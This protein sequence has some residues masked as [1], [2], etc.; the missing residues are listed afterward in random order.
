MTVFANGNVVTAHEV[1]RGTVS[2][3]SGV[4]GQVERY[5]TAEDA[6][7]VDLD[8]DYLLPGI[9]ELHTDVLERH[10]IPRPGAEWPRVAAVV[11]YDSQLI[12]AG[13]TTVLDSLAIGYLF[14]TAQRPR[15]PRP[16][17]E[18]IRAA[19]AADLLR[20]DHY[21]HMRCEVSTELV[22]DDFTPF[23]DDPL[24]RLV[25]LMDHSP[26]QRQ[27]VSVET[28]RQFNQARYGLSDT[29]VDELV[30]TRIEAR[31]RYAE[32]HREAIT[33]LC[34]KHGLPMASHDDALVTHVE[35]AVRAGASIAEFPTTLEAARTARDYGLAV[36]AGAPN[37]VRGGSHSGNISV[38]QLAA[39][40]LLDILSSDYVPVSALHGAFI[41]HLHHGMSL[42]DAVATI[43]LTPARRVGL[44]DRGEIA[45]GKR[46]DLVRVRLAG[47]LPLVRGV[48]RQGAR[49][50]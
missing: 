34:R 46:A 24:V 14:D 19:Q 37:L 30:R 27:Y 13:I 9:V 40:R 1:F 29:Q 26:G 18:A 2:V 45:V 4:I 22:V 6:S 20:A 11:G 3:E 32:R 48:W 7:F 49:V 36:L 47:D 17:V 31:G 39:H 43:S 15:N 35:D 12:G 16:L 23:A 21:L 50:A 44:D 33:A 10:A 28:Y 25:S 38:A 8:G 42:A 5:G 41:L